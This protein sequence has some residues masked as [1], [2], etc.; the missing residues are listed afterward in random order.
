MMR[1]KQLVLCFLVVMVLFS[2]TGCFEGKNDYSKQGVCIVENTSLRKEP[3][4]KGDWISS[5]ALG[6]TVKL[7][8]SPIKDEA[9]PK[10]EYI[11]IK[12]SDGT[13]GYASNWC[14][15]GGA[16]VGVIQKT[17]KIYK[18][19]DL[20]AESNHQFEMMNIVAVEEENESAWIRVTGE[21]RSK[22]GWIK[23]E[24]IRKDKED[25]VTAV[26]L[27]KALRE[28]GKTVNNASREEME[29][30]VSKLPYQDSYFVNQVMSKYEEEVYEDE[31]YEDEEVIVDESEDS[32]EAE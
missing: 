30:I 24:F 2:L 27:R 12:L 21:G 31:V 10:V 18:R 16:Y 8:G 14:I 20:L 3:S 6:E 9:D 23:K 32:F 19:P 28:K 15:V 17:T 7:E 5:L 1:V 4:T 25:V 13:K 26:L 29:A 11:K 22:K